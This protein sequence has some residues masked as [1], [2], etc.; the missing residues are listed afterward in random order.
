MHTPALTAAISTPDALLLADTHDAAEAAEAAASGFSRGLVSVET[1]ITTSDRAYLAWRRA[2]ERW[3]VL[4]H[5]APG[6]ADLARAAERARR[7]YR[8]GDRA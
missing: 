2:D 4:P 7:A 3:A 6:A 1:L 5:D 8:A